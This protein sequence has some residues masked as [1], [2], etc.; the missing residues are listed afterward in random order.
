MS[1]IALILVCLLAFQVKHFLADFCWQTAYMLRGKGLYMH[2]GGLLHAGLH[3]VLSLPVLL[4]F[5]P[6]GAGLA[7]AVCGAEGVVHYHI[8]WAKEHILSAENRA[9]QDRNYW[10]VVGADQALHQVTML[11]MAGAAFVL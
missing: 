8:D 2:P 6:L 10:I 1:D 9:A 3:G 4:L 11:A 5:S 7:L